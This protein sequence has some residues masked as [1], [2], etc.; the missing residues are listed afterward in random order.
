MS[1]QASTIQ[2]AHAG[3]RFLELE[4]DLG[5]VGLCLEGDGV[6]TG[7]IN[8]AF[9]ESGHKV[10]HGG[11]FIVISTANQN[12]RSYH[13]ERLPLCTTAPKFR[14]VQKIRRERGIRLSDF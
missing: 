4:I 5:V 9:G 13:A 3:M 12:A 2:N 6:E 8:I 14:R 1:K 7:N 11:F 10:C